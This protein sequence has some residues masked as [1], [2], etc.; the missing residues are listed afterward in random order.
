[1]K[2]LKDYSLDNAGV[3]AAVREVLQYL[4][5]DV[6][7]YSDAKLLTFW[8]GTSFEE[9]KVLI[10]G[11]NRVEIIKGLKDEKSPNGEFNE[12]LVRVFRE[13]FNKFVEANLSL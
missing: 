5:V 6:S 2:T 12:H 11:N 13:A 4:K 3:T 1:M 10:T 9:K 7:Q 8:S